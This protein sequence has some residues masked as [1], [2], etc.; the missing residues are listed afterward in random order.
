MTLTPNLAM[1]P[2]VV[3]ADA[4][5]WGDKSNANLAL[6]D[7]FAGNVAASILSGLTLSTSGSS[8]NFTCA[9][10]IAGSTTGP[11][12]ALGSPITKSTSSWTVGTS[13]G[14]LDTGSIANDTWYHVW[15]IK[16]PDTGVV[17]VLVSLSAISPTMPP[18]YTLKRRIGALKTNGSAQWINFSQVGD[19]FLWLVPG[20]DLSTSSLGTSE[21]LTTLSSVPSGIKVIA[22]LRGDMNHASANTFV[23]VNSP[24]VTNAAP[25]AGNYTAIQQV[26]AQAVALGELRIRTNTSGQIRSRSSASTTTLEILTYGWIDPRG[27]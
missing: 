10:G 15:L 12:M 18:N 7:T 5:T 9:A 2:C 21:L 16:R 26:G 19:E 4:D 23:L 3:G 13:N 25:S 17:D 11:L 8:A 6:V 27:R 14:G 22:L 24:D 1:N 20:A